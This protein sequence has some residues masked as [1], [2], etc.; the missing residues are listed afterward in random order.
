[1]RL[2]NQPICFGLITLLIVAALSAPPSA[3]AQNDLEKVVFYV[4]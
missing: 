1:M 4:H 2:R 3:E